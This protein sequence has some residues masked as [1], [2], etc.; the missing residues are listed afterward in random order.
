MLFFSLSFFSFKCRQLK[1]SHFLNLRSSTFVLQLQTS[2][3]LAT[4]VLVF[5]VLQ[6]N[7]RYV[8]IC[9]LL[10]QVAQEDWFLWFHI[11]ILQSKIDY[12]ETR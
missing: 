6:I 3:V 8:E 2:L 10:N 7:K 11:E 1:Y 9:S 12:T 4:N 5:S